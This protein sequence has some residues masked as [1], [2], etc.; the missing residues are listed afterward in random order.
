LIIG[1]YLLL[2]PRVEPA[3]S[4][5]ALKILDERYAKGEITREQYSEMK[6]NLSSK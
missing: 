3:E 5:S 6:K 2:K 1:A 4:E